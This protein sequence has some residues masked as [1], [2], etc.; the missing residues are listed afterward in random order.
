MERAPPR[1]LWPKD[2]LTVLIN[3]IGD[4]HRSSKNLGLAERYYLLPLD[5]I[6]E[7]VDPEALQRLGGARRY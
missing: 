3:S 6:P 7:D 4:F 5:L 2:A 1:G